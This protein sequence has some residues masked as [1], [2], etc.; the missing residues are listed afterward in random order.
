MARQ[1]SRAILVVLGVATAVSLWRT[2]ALERQKHRLS[3][4]Y[5]EAQGLVAQL[6]QERNHL[7]G[8]MAA[9]RQTVETQAGEL[10]GLRHELEEVQGRLEQTMA[11]IASLQQEQ[12]QLRQHNASLSMRL[13]AVSA[14][15]AQLEQRLSS[16]SELKLAIRDVKRKIWQ[17]RWAA[18]RARMDQL[19][20]DDLDRLAS[21]NRGY[22]IRDGKSTLSSAARLQVHVLEPQ[23]Q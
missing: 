5:T 7:N 8:E 3:N 20:R 2:A 19:R 12:E 23:S 11:D 18:F 9:A 15:K 10:A 22:I 13:S 16:L 14:E 6:T 1:R 21:G 17:S 4:A